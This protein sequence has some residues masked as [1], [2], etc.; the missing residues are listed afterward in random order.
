MVKALA[1]SIELLFAPIIVE[2]QQAR[3]PLL[4]VLTLTAVLMLGSL[5]SWPQAPPSGEPTVLGVEVNLPDRAVFYIPVVGDGVDE[6]HS[7]GVDRQPAAGA[8]NR[9]GLVAWRETLRSC[10]LTG[11]HSAVDG[12]RCVGLLDSS[13]KSSAR[14]PDGRPALRVGT[15]IPRSTAARLTRP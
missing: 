10:D 13:E 1:V 9:G 2:T 7:Y 8:S 11:H 15:Q 4:Y 5:R 14:R 6:P 12:N 3:R